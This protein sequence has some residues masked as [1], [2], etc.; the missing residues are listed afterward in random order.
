MSYAAGDVCC[1]AC[2]TRAA[3]PASPG[4][5]RHGY[6]APRVKARKPSPYER[7][8]ERVYRALQTAGIMVHGS[9]WGVFGTGDPRLP[10]M[11]YCPVCG[12]GTVAVRLIDTDPP[13]LDVDDCSA[14]CSAETVAKA[15]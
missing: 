8:A 4:A 11:G 2:H 12:F 6:R 9:P 15:L 1:A 13:E 5:R 7:L 3:P 14:G 10:L